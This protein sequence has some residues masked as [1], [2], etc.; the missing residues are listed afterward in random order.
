MQQKYLIE[1]SACIMANKSYKI[2]V[3]YVPHTANAH[4]NRFKNGTTSIISSH[5]NFISVISLEKTFKQE[6]QCQNSRPVPFN[7]FNQSRN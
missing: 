2:N 3:N 6:L 4:I 5:N 1:I 7:P